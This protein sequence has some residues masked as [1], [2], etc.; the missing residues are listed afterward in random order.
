MNDARRS[1]SYKL[2]APTLEPSA[3][4]ER[5]RPVAVTLPLHPSAIADGLG[6]RSLVGAKTARLWTEGPGSD[7]TRAMVRNG[8]IVEA[9]DPKPEPAAPAPAAVKAKE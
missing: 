8:S 5:G 9:P 6:A 1:K 4:D 2:A 7:W 3:G